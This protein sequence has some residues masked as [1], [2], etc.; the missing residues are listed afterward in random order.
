MRVQ[1]KID[2]SDTVP[3][4][5]PEMSGDPNDITTWAFRCHPDDEATVRA[6]LHKAAAAAGGTNIKTGEMN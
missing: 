3:K 4:G 1:W 2:V 5:N 6:I